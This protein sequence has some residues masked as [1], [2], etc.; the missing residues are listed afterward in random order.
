M[1]NELTKPKLNY[2]KKT[3]I[4]QYAND[5]ATKNSDLNFVRFPNT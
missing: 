1:K 5:K 4:L 2:L 3:F